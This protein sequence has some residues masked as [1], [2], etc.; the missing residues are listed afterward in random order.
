MKISLFLKIFNSI[1]FPLFFLLIGLLIF[2]YPMILNPDNMPG[3]IVDSRFVNYI[4]EHYYLFLKQAPTHSSFWTLPMFY[5]M[6]DT[7]ALSETLLGIS[8]IYIL[9]RFFKDPQTS[10]QIVF[11]ILNILNFITFYIFSRK[12][13]KL[14]SF[15]SSFASFFFTFCLPRYIHIYHIQMFIQFYMILSVF[16]LC[17]IKKENSPNKNKLYF[18]LS[19]FFFVAQTYSC[20]YF[21]WFMGFSLPFLMGAFLLSKDLKTKFINLCKCFDKSYFL[22]LLLNI[23]F[24]M[25]LAIKYLSVGEHFKKYDSLEP[26]SF[27]VSQSFL[28]NLFIDL[29]NYAYNEISLGI[30]FI[31]SLIVLIA[32]LKSKYK[33]PIIFFLFSLTLCFTHDKI[34]QFLY[35]YF[36][37]FRTI[38]AYGRYI[39]ILVP[40]FAILISNFLQKQKKVWLSIL[41][42]FLIVLEYIPYS[43]NFTWTK[44]Q[45][46][47][48][49]KSLN[50]D[51]TCKIVGMKIPDTSQYSVYFD[52]DMNVMWW[53]LEHRAYSLNGYSAFYYD[54]L[55]NYADKKCILQLKE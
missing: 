32:L 37:P 14:N 33:Y 22:I 50:F 34:N 49:I 1:F 18:F 19:L 51:E 20:F 39:F 47:E 13:F 46:K 36:Y 28:D 38:R 48:L 27:F 42:I 25:P 24:L 44:T 30:G 31:T 45:H 23:L 12:I 26:I 55:E 21:A 5:P 4:L 2:C 10:L 15:Y 41:I 43:S 17:L 40:I 54:I 52:Y 3:E 7:L 53:A 35:D 8:P 6:K 29:S 11:V 16:F 9:I